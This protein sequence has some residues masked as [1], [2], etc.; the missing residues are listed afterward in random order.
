MLPCHAVRHIDNVLIKNIHFI[1]ALVF[2]LTLAYI[3]LF[4][5]TK[6]SHPP[7]DRPVPKKNRNRIYRI[8]GYVMLGCI[9]LIALYFFWLEEWY[10][11]LSAYDPVFWLESVALW[12]FGFSWLTKGLLFTAAP[13]GGSRQ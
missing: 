4:L 2:F 9:A 13:T 10:P 3:S 1:S 7:S 5:F 12:A 6:S 8:C 11:G